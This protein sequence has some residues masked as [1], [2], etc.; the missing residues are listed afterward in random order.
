M[1]LSHSPSIVSDG[2]IVY[3]DAANRR[4]YSGSGT[5]WFDLSGNNNHATLTN[6]PV[7][8][9]ANGGNIVF[10]GSN[11]YAVILGN[12]STLSILSV[13]T[14]ELILKAPHNGNK[15]IL[16]KGTNDK[17]LIQPD[18]VSTNMYYGDY[19]LF[20][21]TSAILNNNWINICVVQ[22]STFRSL[23]LNGRLLSTVNSGNK[24]ANNSDIVLM[25]RSGSVGQQGS[26]S[27]LKVYNKPLSL[28][29]INQNFNA[30]RNRFGI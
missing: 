9:S 3:L 4:S 23:Y 20:N 7:F 15:V 16:E 25:S 29:E 22:A 14:A 6:G 1:A 17:M 18:G 26:V 2:L 8:N 5:S 13:Y 30:T 24:V 12:T 27:I 10:D 28:A 19:S 21:G 11:D